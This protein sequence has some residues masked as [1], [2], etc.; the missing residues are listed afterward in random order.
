MYTFAF[1]LVKATMFN[2]RLIITL[3]V[4]LCLFACH[5]TPH[6][7]ET[8]LRAEQLMDVAPDSVLTL[9][10]GFKDSVWAESEATQMYYK[11]LTIK[12]NDK[13]YISHTSDSLMKVLVSY[14]ESHGTSAQLMEVYYYQGSVYR[15]LQDAPRAL[16]Y[17]QKAIDASVDGKEYKILGR[18]YSQM[19]ILYMYQRVYDDALPILNNS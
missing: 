1:V 17:F 5:Y 14:Y 19:G 13:C 3:G 10:A 6:Y 8:M 18:V 9:L 15:D 2:L 4:L 7:P 12:A 11:L 16:G